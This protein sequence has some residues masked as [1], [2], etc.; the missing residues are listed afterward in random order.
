M[1]GQC[2]GDPKGVLG[3]VLEA[4]RDEHGTGYEVARNW[5]KVVHVVQSCSGDGFVD[6]MLDVE[7]VKKLACSGK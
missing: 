5:R 3:I 6:G 1:R 7:R 2:I 4:S